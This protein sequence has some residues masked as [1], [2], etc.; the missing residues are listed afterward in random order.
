MKIRKYCNDLIIVWS[1]IKI[2]YKIKIEI[3]KKRIN[4]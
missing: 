1:D 4:Y 2:I 3:G